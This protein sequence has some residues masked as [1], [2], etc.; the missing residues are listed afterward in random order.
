MPD[1]A[2]SSPCLAAV[3]N[4]HSKVQ[5]HSVFQAARMRAGWTKLG[6]SVALEI[7]GRANGSRITASRQMAHALRWKMVAIVSR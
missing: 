6:F 5:H 1:V 4:P 3:K 7:S 2:L